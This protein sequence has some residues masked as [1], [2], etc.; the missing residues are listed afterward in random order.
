MYS[1]FYILQLKLRN[2]VTTEQE[3]LLGEKN[4]EMEEMRKD[5]ESTKTSLRNKSE[6]VCLEHCVKQQ[7]FQSLPLHTGPLLNCPGETAELWQNAVEC[8]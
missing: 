1:L 6:E 8:S 5:L 7:L 3:K 2:Q 4:R